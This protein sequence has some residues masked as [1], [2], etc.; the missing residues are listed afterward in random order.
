MDKS[1]LQETHRFGG[2]YSKGVKQFISKCLRCKC[3]CCKAIALDNVPHEAMWPKICDPFD[4]VGW[5]VNLLKL[6]N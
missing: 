6:I 3:P 5:K 1:W 2:K 4:D